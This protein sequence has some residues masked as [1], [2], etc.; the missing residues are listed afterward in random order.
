MDAERVL[1]EKG[2]RSGL[3][4][5]AAVHSTALGVAVG[6]CRMWAYPD[7]RDG[8]DDPCGRPRR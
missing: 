7:W 8:L 1:I 6:G 3:P 2:P 5:I 4:I